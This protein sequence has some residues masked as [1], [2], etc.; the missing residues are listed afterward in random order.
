MDRVRAEYDAIL[1]QKLNDQYEYFVR[2]IDEQIQQ[3]FS[4]EQ[5]PPS[6]LS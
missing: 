4:N 6:Y 5:Q 2:F 1:Q 3:R